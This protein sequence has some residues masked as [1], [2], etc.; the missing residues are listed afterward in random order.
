[1]MAE[2]LQ[3]DLGGR[4]YPVHVGSGTLG[5][6]GSLISASLAGN[7][8]VVVSDTNVAGLYAD[9]VLA[10]LRERG[11]EA[12]LETVPAGES[13][14][15]LECFADLQ[16]RLLSRRI[17]RNG[18]ILAL[19]GGCVGDLAGF[20]A[21]TLYRGV[22]L[23]Q[24]PTTLLAQV[25]S[26]VGGKTGVNTPHGKNLVGAFHQPG[27][28]LADVDVLDTLP[29]VEQKAGYAEMLKAGLLGDR[30]F[31]GW[32][33]DRGAELL[34]GNRD[35]RVHGIRQ[36]IAIKAGIVSGDEREHGRRA[37]LN[38]GHTFAHALEAE[39][40]QTGALPHGYAVSVGLVLAAECS[41]RMGFCPE[42]VTAEIRGHLRRRG[43][44]V[45]TVNLAGSP[46]DPQAL[47]AR[48]EH[49]KKVRDGNRVLILL[50]DIGDAFVCAAPDWNAVESV[51]VE[52]CGR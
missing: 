28:V 24:A 2:A 5:N 33:A 7:R 13:A 32:L 31:A 22:R 30:N 50:R 46:F 52:A 14:K 19:G 34:A 11:L 10:S 38:L 40:G 15:T 1:M 51:L 42:G 6:A 16:R 18:A 47:L 12:S 36:S 21:A 48:M 23:I 37:L 8:V 3:V 27:C 45:R 39:E 26:S 9:L 49:D 44:P 35:A 17:G 29:E 20:A 43:L 25:D 41:E 4:T